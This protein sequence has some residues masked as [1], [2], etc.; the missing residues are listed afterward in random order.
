MS[1]EQVEGE[2]HARAC[3]L[4]LF[5]ALA[6]PAEVSVVLHYIHYLEA[7]F[8]LKTYINVISCH[9]LPPPL[10]FQVKCSQAVSAMAHYVLSSY[11]RNQILRVNVF[12]EL[13][14]LSGK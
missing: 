8:S 1:L 9:V 13:V 2:R 14:P 7:L 12:L 6:V 4:F 11:A 5:L 10:V 3:D